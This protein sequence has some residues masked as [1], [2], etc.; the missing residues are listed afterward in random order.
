[1]HVTGEKPDIYK[2]RRQMA[3]WESIFVICHTMNYFLHDTN[4]SHTHTHTHPHTKP[5]Q[6]KNFKNGLWR[7]IKGPKI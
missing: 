5:E 3:N 1:M 4:R 2:V 6:G 7:K